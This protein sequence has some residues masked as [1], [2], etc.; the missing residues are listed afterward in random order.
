MAKGYWAR[1][2]AV[3]LIATTL[4]IMS[5]C[6]NKSSGEKGNVEL[7]WWV[8]DP[9][10]VDV[11][12]QA[13]EKFSSLHPNIKVKVQHQPG[14]FYAKLQTTLAANNGPDITWINGPNFQKFQD[15]GFLMDLSEYVNRDDFGFDGF[16]Q[17]IVELYKSDGKHYGIPKDIDSIGLYYN[18][19]MFDAAGLDYPTGEWTWEDLR[20]AAKKLTI[21]ENGETTQWGLLLPDSTTIHF[22][23]LL[24]NGVKILSEDKKSINLGSPEAIEAIQYIQDMVHVDKVSPD[25][26]YLL[27]NDPSQM[28]QSGKAAMIYEGSWM[29]RPFYD[30]LKDNVDVSPLPQGKEKAFAIHGVG[31]VANAK[32]KHPEEVWE[33]LKYLG[34]EEFANL[35]AET[36]LVIPSIESAHEKWTESVPMRLQELAEYTQF[37]IPYPTSFSTEWQQPMFDHFANIWIGQ[38]TVEDGMT[39][40][41]QEANDILAE[42]GE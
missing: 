2:F 17:P 37:G 14:D 32:T 22:A 4:M 11:M 3:I 25:G 42:S 6:S 39:K 34:S 8:A 33:L 30:A 10:Q 41:Q 15:K 31:W 12:E 24:Q 28:F 27:E 18:K 38:E 5:A 40:L 29:V 20:D 13:V 21:T 19:D 7:S 35:Q 9:D 36:G 23:F 1:A 26:Q 16:V